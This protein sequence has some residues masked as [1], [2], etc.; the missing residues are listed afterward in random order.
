MKLFSLSKQS[1]MRQ[2]TFVSLPIFLLGIVLIS[3]WLG[4]RIESRTASRLG[5]MTGLYVESFLSPIVQSMAQMDSLGDEERGLLDTLLSSTP[6]GQ[7]VLQ[8]KVW[9]LKG[10]IVYGKKNPHEA[11][12]HEPDEGLLAAYQ[13]NVHSS[14]SSRF[15]SDNEHSPFEGRRMMETYVPIRADRTGR[16]IAVAEFYQSTD[17]LVEMARSAQIEA[18]LV[19]TGVFGLIYLFLWQI[20]R[21]GSNTIEMQHRQLEEKLNLLITL[22]KRNDELNERVR[23][24]AARATALNEHFLHRISADLHDG[25]GQDLGLAV[26]RAETILHN[27]KHPNRHEGEG[28]CLCVDHITGLSHLLQ[29]A[30]RELRTVSAGLR[31]PDLESLNVSQIIARA[32]RDYEEKTGSTV[33]LALTQDIPEAPLPVRITLYRVLQ[34]SLSNG[35]RHAGGKGQ[36]AD[37]SQLDC[38][39]QVRIRDAGPGFNPDEAAGD[40]HLGLK[41]M[42]ERVELLGG[43]FQIDS[44]RGAGT[45]IEFTLPLK[46]HEVED[47]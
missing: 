34:E 35:F 6:M 22:N 10:Q 7:K 4:A 13:G 28:D 2:F 18:W 26:M 1:L 46:L 20:V 24:A 44:R 15:F 5:A 19:V 38:S 12:D 39:L 9:D 23:R 47:G 31:L 41:I 29:S 14:I 43:A 36:H 16:V 27:L 17:E 3:A 42:R 30:L 11:W 8:F 21:R 32:V 33:E 37:I 45:T 25:P 40:G